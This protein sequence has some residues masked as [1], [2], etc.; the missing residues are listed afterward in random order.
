MMVGI[1]ACVGTELYVLVTRC[2]VEPGGPD[3]NLFQDASRLPFLAGLAICEGFEPSFERSCESPEARAA[4]VA[5]IAK[6]MRDVTSD[7]DCALYSNAALQARLEDSCPGIHD[8]AQQKA[9]RT[10]AMKS[11]MIAVAGIAGIYGLYRWMK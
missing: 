11:G 1:P 3:C 8:E 7:P 10:Q 4:T 2:H 5:D 6:C 9:E